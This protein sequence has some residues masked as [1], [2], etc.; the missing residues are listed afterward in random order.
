VPVAVTS[1]Y[2]LNAAIQLIGDDQAPL[3]GQWPTF[4]NSAAGQVGNAIYQDTV[5]ACARKFGYDFSRNVA[6][7]ALTPNAPPAGWT[8]E[9]AYPTNGI[10]VRQLIPQAIVDKNDPSPVNWTVGNATVNGTPTKV[11]WADLVNAQASFTN[12][13][14]EG[15]WDALFVEEVIRMLASGLA[16][17]VAGRP[18]S[19]QIA[20]ESAGMFGQIG[21]TRDS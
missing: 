20:M 4:D 12:Q 21:Q 15:L 5:Q 17:G 3:T 1:N 10:Q 18:E 8:Y 6:A 14:P 2:I 7:L 16:M 11:I 9:Y 13:P 19:A